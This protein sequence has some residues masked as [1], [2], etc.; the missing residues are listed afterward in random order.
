M[1]PPPAH[2]ST[3][4]Y[5]KFVVLYCKFVHVATSP[6]HLPCMTVCIYVLH[7]KLYV[8]P[9]PAHASIMHD[10]L[11]I[12]YCKLYMLPPPAHASTM[13]DIL[14]ILY[15]KLY[16]LPPPAHAFT[17]HDSLYILYCIL[18]TPTKRQVSKR[19][20]SK[21]PVSKRL[22]RQVYKT[23]GLQNVRFTKRQVYKTSGLQNVRL[24]KSIHIYSVLVVGG[25]PQ[26][27][28]QPC[29][30]AKWW[31]C[32]ILYFRGVSCHISPY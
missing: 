8:L 28:L 17:V 29:L 9:P 7:C 20:V 31:Q 11:D 32:F 10:S 18:G 2:A 16:M 30:Q 26:V 19:Q 23:S 5:L 4:H 21:R 13:H 22:K 1:L 15:C 27:L 6:M 12:L 3:M 14:Y 24:Q 25:N